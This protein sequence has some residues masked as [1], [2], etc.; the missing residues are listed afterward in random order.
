MSASIARRPPR[1]PWWGRCVRAPGRRQRPPHRRR[2]RRR[3]PARRR[4]DDGADAKASSGQAAKNGQA[5]GPPA[6][7]QGE[8]LF[9][10]IGRGPA[11]RIVHRREGHAHLF[12]GHA[13]GGGDQPDDGS[14]EPVEAQVSRAVVCIWTSSSSPSTRNSTPS[15]STGF[16]CRI[17][18]VLGGAPR[19]RRLS[20][21]AADGPALDSAKPRNKK[22]GPPPRWL[23]GVFREGAEQLQGGDEADHAARLPAP[24]SR[25]HPGL[26][27]PRFVR[28]LGAVPA[29]VGVEPRYKGWPS[30]IR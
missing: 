13:Q 14:G 11:R 15:T 3:S 17:A 27:R 6:A 29:P 4:G 18:A 30:R 7:A 21:P 8:G 9:Q 16:P 19:R 1:F 20:L 23:L 26:G 2:W 12:V 25:R 24:A 22:S 28:T 5:P 10:A